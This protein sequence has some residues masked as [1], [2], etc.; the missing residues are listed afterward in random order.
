V[1]YLFDGR[2]ESGVLADDAVV[3]SDGRFMA[4]LTDVQL[5]APCDPRVIV[6]AGNNYGSKGAPRFFLKTANSVTGPGSAVR[7]PPEVK[8]LEYEGELAVVIGRT[9]HEVP[10]ESYRDYVLGYTCANDITADDWRADGQWFRA[11]SSDTFCPLGPW[12][13]TSV[14]DP[15]AL[16]LRTIVNGSVVQDSPTGQLTAGVGEL[17]A[18][19]TRWITLQPG[20]VVLTGTPA[21]VGPLARGDVVDVDIDGIG[22]LTNVI[23]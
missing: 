8:R 18:Y 15:A 5:L 14:D 3:D 13:E 2:V 22:T 23:A 7:Y 1:R 16:R 17:L 9:A 4:A 12:I 11:K 6:G 10:E 20:D 19:I 21:G